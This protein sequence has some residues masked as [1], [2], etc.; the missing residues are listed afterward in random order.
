MLL[1]IPAERIEEGYRALAYLRL[2]ASI[3]EASPETRD[4]TRA[5]FRLPEYFSGLDR[6]AASVAK[7]VPMIKGLVELHM[8]LDRSSLR[9][10]L[11]LSYRWCSS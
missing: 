8:Q 3:R 11:F 9:R 1:A 2:A 10:S 5:R 4:S 7:S 6:A